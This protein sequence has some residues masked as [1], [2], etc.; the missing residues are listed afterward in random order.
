MRRL[1]VLV[2]VAGLGGG[3][4]VA[5]DPAARK[6]CVAEGFVD[7]AS[8]WEGATPPAQGTASAAGE[9]A[10]FTG[11]GD[12]TVRFPA[13]GWTDAGVYYLARDLADGATLT[14]DASGTSWTFGAG[15]YFSNWQILTLCGPG[16]GGVSYPYLL[17]VRFTT[18][19]SAATAPVFTLSDGIVAFTRDAVNGSRLSLVRGEWN[20]LSSPNVQLTFF[21]GE[22]GANE[23]RVSL[24]DGSSLKAPTVS[25]M[26]GAGIPSARV[27]VAGGAH[28]MGT[29]VVG[30]AKGTS[31]TPVALDVQGGSLDVANLYVG[32]R[33]TTAANRL[34]LARA[35]RLTAANLRIGC[36]GNFGGA[37]AVGEDAAFLVTNVL[38]MSAGNAATSTLSI[39]GHATATI[40]HLRSCGDENAAFDDAC[41]RFELTDDAELTL[42]GFLKQTA[43]KGQRTRSETVVGGRARLHATATSDADTGG[44]H[45]GGVSG[46][47]G[48]LSGLAKLTVTDD[49]V[50]ETAART[51]IGHTSSASN[52]LEIAGRATFVN[53]NAESGIVLGRGKGGRGALVVKDAAT[54]RTTVLQLSGDLRWGDNLAAEA[55]VDVLGGTVEG[56]GALI[57]NGT[58]AWVNLAGGTSSFQTWTV[59]GEPPYQIADPDWTL[60]TNTVA[61]SG[62]THAVRATTSATSISIGATN[63]NAR[64][65]LAGGEL[66]ATGLI[67]LGIADMQGN[68]ACLAVTGGTLTLA[69]RGDAATGDSKI[70]VGQPAASKG[71]LELLGGEV[72]ANSIRGGS[73]DSTLVADGGTFTVLNAVSGDW[74]LS[75]LKTALLGDGGLTVR[76]PRGIRAV[77]LQSF[78]DRDGAAGLFVKDGVGTLVTSNA[79]AH[80]RTEVAAGILAL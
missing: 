79:S 77:G 14:F 67:A 6:W 16:Y 73:G 24:L 23:D 17:E 20:F 46:A 38:M 54:L 78:A 5:A 69:Q 75:R 50:V 39:G 37:V 68:P 26:P 32:N 42:T 28:E 43:G 9:M 18:S 52:V 59:G 65:H 2:L 74:A 56:S 49:A 64:V 72:I 40:R 55:R 1:F 33:A 48:D 58:N 60:P 22:G 53:S 61:I 8:S 71:R 47:E 19:A 70:M 80:A 63:G 31:A 44:I 51:T 34:S 3:R 4:A 66:N 12:K 35:A 27:L 15:Q 29:L 36:G 21:A 41:A 62:G 25:L 45:L 11:S 7:A 10:Y 13:D 57:L 76:V 30:A